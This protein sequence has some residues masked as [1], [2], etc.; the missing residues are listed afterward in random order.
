MSVRSAHATLLQTRA[1]LSRPVSPNMDTLFASMTILVPN[2]AE[3]VLLFRVVAVYPPC[4]LSWR[5]KVLIYGPIVAFKTSRLINAV[6][7]IERWVQL[8]KNTVNPLMT[9]QEAWDLP[10]AKIEW[11]VQLFD[12]T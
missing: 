1:I 6:I 12:T 4:M 5:R 7:F 9:G 2:F 3:L 8:K 10:N 11:V